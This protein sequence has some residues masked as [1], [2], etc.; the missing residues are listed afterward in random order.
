MWTYTCTMLPPAPACSHNTATACADQPRRRPVATGLL[1][2]RHVDG[3][4]TTPPVAAPPVRPPQVAVKPATVA[5]APCT[6][7]TPS[8]LRV[9]AGQLNTIRVRVRNVDAGS[10]V[11][12]TLPGRR[13]R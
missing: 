13:R 3:Q 6:L 10:T 4:L 11:T 9:R 5:Q 2:A 8:G 12:L 1:A 7:S